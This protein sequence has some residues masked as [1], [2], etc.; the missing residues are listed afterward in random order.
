MEAGKPHDMKL[1]DWRPQHIAPRLA[2]AGQRGHEGGRILGLGG[3][4]QR[5]I[6]P[7]AVAN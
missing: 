7:F 1:P 6:S 3:S 2:V 5:H 4:Q